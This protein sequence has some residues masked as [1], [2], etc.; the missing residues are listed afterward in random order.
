[1]VPAVH[2]ARRSSAWGERL[3]S[4]WPRS[5]EPAASASVRVSRPVSVSSSVS[6]TRVPS[7]YRR[8]LAR[9]PAAETDQCPARSSSRRAKTEGESKRGKQS[10]ST[11]P[12]RCTRAAERQSE[13]RAYS[14]M[15]D[16]I[17]SEG[18]PSK[19]HHQRGTGLGWVGLRSW[20]R[21]PCVWC[22]C[23]RSARAP[24]ERI[25]EGYGPQLARGTAARSLTGAECADIPDVAGRVPDLSR[26][27]RP[28]FPEVD[29]ASCVPPTAGQ[30]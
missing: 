13:R 2:S 18:T 26:A 14:A 19:P 8:R 9:A 24:G 10:Q 6:R 7:R 4:S 12:D 22:V 11:E 15:G 5:L 3:P 1:M 16:L 27:D 29:A 25:V 30:T 17:G 28:A 21:P 23:E 20:G